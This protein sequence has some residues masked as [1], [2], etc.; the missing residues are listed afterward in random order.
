MLA[1]CNLKSSLNLTASNRKFDIKLFYIFPDSV[2]RNTLNYKTEV[3]N[4]EGNRVGM[5]GMFHSYGPYFLN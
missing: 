2:F 4:E 1:F 3:Y 5:S